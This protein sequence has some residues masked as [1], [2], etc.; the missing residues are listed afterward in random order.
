MNK[1]KVASLAALYQ[2][3]KADAAS[4]F[5]VAM[6]LMGIGAAYI[7]VAIG[8]VGRFGTHSLPPYAAAFAPA[9]LWLI[10]VFQSLITLSAMM[11]GVSVH[12]IENELFREAGLPEELRKYVGTRSGDMIMDIRQSKLVHAIA[13]IFVYAGVAAMIVAFTV[14]AVNQAWAGLSAVFRVIIV[15]IYSLAVIIVGLSWIIGLMK[16]NEA[17]AHMDLSA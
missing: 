14:Y 4:T 17:G 9:P 5:N 2:A 16:A 15:I 12:I 3:E 1:D 7:V 6:S 13:T 10:A 11:H 8:Y